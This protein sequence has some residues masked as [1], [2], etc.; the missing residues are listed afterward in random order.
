MMLRK[1]LTFLIF[2]LT[3]STL[4]IAQGAFDK[5]TSPY[6]SVH[7]VIVGVSEYDEIQ[8]LQYADKDA[9]LFYDILS[10]SFPEYVDNFKLIQ[11]QQAS[12]RN[13]KQ[14][15]WNAQQNSKEGDLV[16]IYFSGHGDVMSQPGLNEGFFLAHDASSSRAYFASGAVGFDFVNK[17]TNSITIKKADVWL[18]TDACHAGKVIDQDGANA[19]MLT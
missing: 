5:I 17:M 3:S 12:Q 19:T 14:A 11:N 10:I 8:N 7:A 18:V 15:I 2:T 13:I 1:F 9:Q 16:I 4:I 6:N